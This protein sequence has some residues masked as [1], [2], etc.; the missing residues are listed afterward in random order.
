MNDGFMGHIIDGMII[1]PPLEF[2]ESEE[3]FWKLFNE[4]ALRKLDE[5]TK[6]LLEVYKE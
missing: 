4:D 3:S 2:T 6:V 5:E 1:Q